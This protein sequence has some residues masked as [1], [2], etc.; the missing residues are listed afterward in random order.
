MTQAIIISVLVTIILFL[1]VALHFLWGRI[2][3]LHDSYSK[4]LENRNE[5][6]EDLT[7]AVEAKS[8]T[9]ETLRAE[10]EAKGASISQAKDMISELNIPKNVK[11]EI[12]RRL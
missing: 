9:I 3:L 8:L 2:Q 7:G 4:V 10:M 11:L 5:S 6:I 12:M 1:I